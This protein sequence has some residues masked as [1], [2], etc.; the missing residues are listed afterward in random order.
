MQNLL[1]NKFLNNIILETLRLY[2]PAVFLFDRVALEDHYIEDI[3]IKKGD[4][5]NV[6]IYAMNIDSKVFENPLQF[7]PE[8]WND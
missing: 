4:L 5:V 2:S 8:R 1:E 7:I 6:N 3:K